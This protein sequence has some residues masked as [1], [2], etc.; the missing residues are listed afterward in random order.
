MALKNFKPQISVGNGFKPFPA[1]N[2][3]LWDEVEILRM[4]ILQFPQWEALTP[5]TASKPHALE[6]KRMHRSGSTLSPSA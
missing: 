2:A 5:S 4:D 3:N 1:P 6:W